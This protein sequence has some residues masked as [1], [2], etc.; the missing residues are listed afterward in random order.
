LT[1]FLF[2]LALFSF[3]VAWQEKR[4]FLL[5]LSGFCLV[6]AYLTRPEYLIFYV[7]LTVILL[8]NRRFIDSLMLL[9]PLF[10]L[11]TLYV[12]YLH[13]HTGLWIVSN[14]AMLSPFVSLSA[15][16]SNVPFVSYYFV[17]ALSPLF[18]AL[19]LIGF[20]TSSATYRTLL[21]LLVMFHV[22]S[23]SLISNYT[24]RYSVEF[25]PLC[26]IC[27][28]EGIYLAAAY[29][30]RFSSK[31]RAYQV[32]IFLIVVASVFH[33]YT[34]MRLDRTLH[35]QAGLFLSSH[36]PGSTVAARLPLVA[37]YGKGNNIDLLSHIS[38]KKTPEQLDL[39]LMERRVK[40]LV[41]DEELE[42]E[43]PFLAAYVSNRSPVLTLGDNLTFVRLYRMF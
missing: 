15:S 43:L 16:F 30:A 23:L 39:F 10:V 35:K 9:L 29:I 1:T 13:G 34:P 32:M 38:G 3:Y 22:A 31:H 4:H 12:V 2:S 14:K 42:K 40:Y 8:T 41:V 25:I 28:V 21:L 36:D 19:A 27:A 24:Q 17:V 26:M 5:P 6:L 18:F 33:A 11:G 20:S 7:P 37:F